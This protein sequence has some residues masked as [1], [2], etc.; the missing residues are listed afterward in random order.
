MKDPT[1]PTWPEIFAFPFLIAW[2]LIR[3][4]V[5]RIHFFRNR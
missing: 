1:E 4:A 2:D 3:D 5:K